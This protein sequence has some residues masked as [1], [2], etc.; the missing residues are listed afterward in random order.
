MVLALVG[1]LLT[2]VL[3]WPYYAARTQQV[4]WDRTTLDGARF[5]TSIESGALRRLVLKN[6]LLTLATAGLYWPWAAVALA[7]YRLECV[8][9]ESASTLA[10]LASAVNAPSQGATGEGALDSFGLDIGL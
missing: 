5:R 10:L 4:V 2:Y 3:L 8:Q 1:S 9:V 6:T 7:R